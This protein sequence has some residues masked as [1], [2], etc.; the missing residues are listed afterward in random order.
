M[1]IDY[2]GPFTGAMPGARR[3]R[4]RVDGINLL[5]GI[6]GSLPVGIALYD[7]TAGDF[8]VL[9]CN[10][11][12]QRFL[13]GEDVHVEGRPL[14][15][16]VP[17]AEE[18]GVVAMLR[19]VWADGEAK[20]IRVRT[21]G[22]VWTCDAYP[23]SDP[24]GQVTHVL[25][26]AQEITEPVR[27]GERMHDLE[28]AKSQF[29]RLAS[30]ELRGPIGVLRGYLSMIRDG[31]LGP[32]P[33]SL[34]P[35]LPTMSMKA[36]QM[37]LMI[38]K[39]L[40]A[41]RLEDSRLQLSLQDLDLRQL[42]RRGIRFMRP[43]A[44]PRQRLVLEGASQKVPVRGDPLHLET[45][46]TNLLD[47]AI[48]Y[49]LKGQAVRVSVTVEGDRARLTVRDHGVGIAAED[50]PRLFTRFERL[51]TDET[52]HVSGTGLGLYLSRELARLHGGDLKGTSRLHHGSEFTLSLPLRH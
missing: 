20:Q 45:I 43:M 27:Y 15:E 34:A 25:T 50:L 41:A 24:D 18:L 10:P 51:P 5:P 14:L 22:H 40:A 26:V 30:H 49:S 4:P 8:E 47:N 28:Q 52:S 1:N 36:D 31:S 23:V 7:T 32:M 48:K 37:H 17:Q 11:A 19:R 9:Y 6:L 46:I 21:G 33:K 13:A 39:M 3:V 35:I 12:Y 38:N 44:Q 29:L 42:A 16:V 2:E